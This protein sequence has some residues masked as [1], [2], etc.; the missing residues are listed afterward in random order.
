MDKSGGKK[1][2]EDTVCKKTWFDWCNLLLI[3]CIP[4]PPIRN[5]GWC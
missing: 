2:E 4:D 1:D 3:N 5:D